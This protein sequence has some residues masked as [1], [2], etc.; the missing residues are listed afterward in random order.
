MAIPLA[1]KGY[2][3]HAVDHVGHGHSDGRKG[4]ISNY[5]SLV[6]DFTAFATSI[7]DQYNSSGNDK[8]VFIFAHS[9]GTLI[10]LMSLERL[11]FVQSLIFS[12]CALVSGP[13]ASSPFGISCLYP[14]SQTSVADC[15][16]SLTSCIDPYGLAAPLVLKEV[17]SSAADLSL[18][19][20]DAR[21]FKP[22]IMNKTAFELIKMIKVVK[23]EKIVALTKPFLCFHGAIDTIC[24]SKGTELLYN[25]SGTFITNKSM[26]IIPN[27]KHE[28]IH[29]VSPYKEQIIEMIINYYESQYHIKNDGQISTVNSL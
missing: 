25:N 29:E 24:L 4:L 16:L 15:L 3:V 27:C 10:T 22:I 26:E 9:M 1:Q 12:G 11:P 8:K 21:R 19:K 18:I 20:N 5:H 23:S 14:L 6:D 2:A 13:G 17:T 28:V 7:N